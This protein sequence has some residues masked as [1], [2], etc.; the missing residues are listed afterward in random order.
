[1][2]E[3]INKTKK[4]FNGEFTPKLKNVH[5][6][7]GRVALHASNI[8]F[9]HPKN[10]KEVSFDAPLPLDFSNVIKNLESYE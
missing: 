7:I 6:T 5:K 9:I 8:K 2:L 4:S 10:N 3:A 1:M